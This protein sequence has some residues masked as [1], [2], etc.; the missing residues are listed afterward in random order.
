V[1]DSFAWF[2]DIN[3][4]VISTISTLQNLTYAP[5][6][7]LAEATSTKRRSSAA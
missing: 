5:V 6:T 3:L 7:I 4:V 2:L 1:S